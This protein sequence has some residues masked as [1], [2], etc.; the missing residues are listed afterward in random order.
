MQG[1]GKRQRGC[2]VVPLRGVLLKSNVLCRCSSSTR[3][4]TVSFDISTRSTRTESR[5][6]V[7]LCSCVSERTSRILRQPPW[8]GALS[9]S[10]LRALASRRKSSSTLVHQLHLWSPRCSLFKVRISFILSLCGS[11]PSATSEPCFREGAFSTCVLPS[12][13]TAAHT[14]Q[15]RAVLEALPTKCR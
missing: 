11:A 10:W 3:A 14:T 12:H 1:C 7:V 15:S 5:A 6:V 8:H 4:H 9:N 13:A 2:G